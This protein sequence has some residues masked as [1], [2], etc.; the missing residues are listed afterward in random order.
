MMAYQNAA[1]TGAYPTPYYPLPYQPAWVPAQVPQ[2]QAVLAEPVKSQPDR[3]VASSPNLAVKKRSYHVKSVPSI[4]HVP[5]LDDPE[6]LERWKM[7]RRKKF[8]RAVEHNKEAENAVESADTEA[9]GKQSKDRINSVDG[10]IPS[11]DG[12][13]EEGALPDDLDSITKS[14]ATKRPCK[15]FARGKCRNGD[16]CTFLHAFSKK[17][18][19][20]TL[21]ERLV[22]EEDNNDM[23]KF[24]SF[25]KSLV[26]DDK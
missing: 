13:D 23:L 12:S 3:P 18:R 19:K 5:N 24:Y 14:S 16:K 15:Y 6:E 26:K 10:V 1:A 17:Q 25:I 9:S 22:A 11:W 7:E 21:F 8:P 2:Q 20:E 4:P